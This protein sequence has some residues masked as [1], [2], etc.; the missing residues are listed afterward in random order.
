AFAEALL[1]RASGRA[2]V[3]ASI[4]AATALALAGRADRA[5]EVALRAHGVHL[6][7][8]DQ[9]LLARPWIHEVS[10][11]FAAIEGGP[12]SD[13]DARAGCGYAAALD[14]G[15]QAAQAWFVLIRA[16]AALLRGRPTTAGRWFTE[17]AARFA[18]IGEY[19]PRRWAV[20]GRAL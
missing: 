4:A 11:G 15:E 6:G 2:L 17:S 3:N 18:D 10:R 5:R 8:G 20:A 12:L 13:A 19:G 1:L 9:Q 16:R 7:L 14:G